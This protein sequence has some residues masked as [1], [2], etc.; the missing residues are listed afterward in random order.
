MTPAAR[1]IDPRDV[2]I[3]V[4]D[5]TYRVTFWTIDGRVSRDFEVT[6]AAS[7][8]EAISWAD[9]HMKP[10]ELYV[11]GAIWSTLAQDGASETVSLRLKG[12]A[13][14]GHSPSSRFVGP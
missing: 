8:D 11:L 9:K 6:G 10:G 3:E 5:P 2:S 1:P 13:P 14:S 7:I 12:T 4:D